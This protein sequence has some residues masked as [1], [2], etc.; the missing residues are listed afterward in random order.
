LLPANQ[1]LKKFNGPQQQD[2]ASSFP[3]GGGFNALNLN[4]QH[5]AAYLAMTL[6]R[7]VDKDTLIQ[8]VWGDIQGSQKRERISKQL[9]YGIKTTNTTIS[10]K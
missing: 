9:E 8:L 5:F 7:E 6:C 3:L 1:L 10:L 2:D 4:S